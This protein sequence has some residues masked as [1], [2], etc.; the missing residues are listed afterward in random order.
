MT[1]IDPTHQIP[2]V[3]FM[4]DPSDFCRACGGTGCDRFYDYERRT[5]VAQS[6]FTCGGTG[7]RGLAMWVQP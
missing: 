4:F 5:W 3:A 6:C 2:E 1:A 7:N